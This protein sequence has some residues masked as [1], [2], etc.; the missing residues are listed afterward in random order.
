MTAH[1]DPSGTP[2]DGGEW[3]AAASVDADVFVLRP[4]YRALL[5]TADGLRGGASDK[6]SDRILGNAESTAPGAAR[7]AVA[8][9]AAAP[10]GVPEC[11]TCR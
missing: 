2:S 1:S 4:D 6:I 11:R 3:L 5:L 9:A 8:R 7:Q 10:C